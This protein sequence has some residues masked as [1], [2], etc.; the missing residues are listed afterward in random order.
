LTAAALK[1]RRDAELR[2]RKA[3]EL[4]LTE[5]VAK[6]LTTWS[7]W[8]AGFATPVLVLTG[9]LI[10]KGYLDVQGDIKAAREQISGEVKQGK[11]QISTSVQQAQTELADAR[12]KILAISQDIGTLQSDVAKYRSVNQHIEQI[13]NDFL[14]LQATVVDLGQKK[15]KA[16]SLQLTGP[17]PGVI[18]LGEL[19]CPKDKAQAGTVSYCSQGSPALLNTMTP[20]GPAR[21]VAS[22]SDI[23][24]QDIS[25]SGRPACTVVTRGTLFVE[26]GAAHQSDS[27]FVCV[28]EASDQY[29]WMR[30]AVTD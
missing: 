9:L 4:E 26:K 14:R 13:Q 10:G 12:G 2:E 18:S 7:K 20:D 30:I 19:G 22:L 24:F 21:P 17:G 6:R 29:R 16:A 11:E 8:V 5:A 27:P 1:L 25:K 28:K 23:G 15:L 3:R